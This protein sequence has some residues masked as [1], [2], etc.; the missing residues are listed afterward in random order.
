MSI[1]HLALFIILGRGIS[2][3]LLLTNQR[4]LYLLYIFT[5][6]A[7]RPFN[8]QGAT[9]SDSVAIVLIFPKTLPPLCLP[10]CDYINPD[11]D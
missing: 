3:M 10:G 1:D 7:V 6:E 9:T 11:L 5:V 2:A 4:P 8:K